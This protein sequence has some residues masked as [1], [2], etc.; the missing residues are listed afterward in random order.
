MKVVR[1]VWSGG[2]AEK[3]YLSLRVLV[4]A[5]KEYLAVKTIRRAKPEECE[6]LSELAFRSKAHWGY[7]DEFMAACRTE[8][9][10]TADDIQRSRF[11][12]LVDEDKLIGF[13]GLVKESD[14][15]YELEA[16]FIE[17]DLI[18]RGD[19][20]RLMDHA[21]QTV[22][23]LGGTELTIQGDPN[24]ADFYA[25]VGGKCIGERESDSVAGRY[26]PLFSI[27]LVE[28]A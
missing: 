5:S 28:S 24:A 12:V 8:L 1:C 25:K 23:A 21:K 27:R 9:T 19:G 18:G 22:K 10:Y 13:Y 3:P 7:S 11:Y 26:L 15:V 16:L 4:V 17:P 6:Q 20:R 2:K 14:T